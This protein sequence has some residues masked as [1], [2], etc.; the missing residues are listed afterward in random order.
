MGQTTPNQV[1]KSF[2]GV[3][4]IPPLDL[5]IN[6]GEFV[7]FVGPSGFIGSPN[8]NLI[9]GVAAKKHDAV[10][11]GI[12]PGHLTVSKSEGAWKGR[13][14][15]AHPGSDAFIHVHDTGLMDMKTVRI[16]DDIEARHGDMIY[17]T[18]VADQLQ[19]FD[20]KGLRIA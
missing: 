3:Q 17:L 18:P 2:G 16:T 7:V 15:A 11:I 9:E 4:V 12:R 10:T 20:T 8:M 1:T 14:V 13:G 5:Q 19:R 6:D